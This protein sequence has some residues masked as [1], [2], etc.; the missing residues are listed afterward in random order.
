MKRGHPATVRPP[1]HEVTQVDDVGA[2]DV[3][4]VVPF[5]IL[6]KDLKAP[7]RIVGFQDG[8]GPIVGVRTGAN[9][10]WLRRNLQVRVVSVKQ[11]PA[12][13]ARSS[14]RPVYASGHCNR[15]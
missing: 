15:H 5:P 8:D 6:A 9:L 1:R 7:W 2:R 10:P 3:R 14:G 13:S 11:T 12:P 4:H